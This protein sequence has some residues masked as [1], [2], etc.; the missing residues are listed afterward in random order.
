MI[1]NHFNCL[2]PRIYK[3]IEKY[4]VQSFQTPT[5]PGGEE[6]AVVIDIGKIYLSR[7]YFINILLL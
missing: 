1:C 4:Y 6:K 2:R 7:L 3:N 5:L